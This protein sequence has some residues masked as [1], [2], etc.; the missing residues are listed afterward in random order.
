[1]VT[2]GAVIERA[3]DGTI[4]PKYRR[5]TLKEAIERPGVRNDIKAFV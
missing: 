2:V 3:K 5:V 4:L 1:M